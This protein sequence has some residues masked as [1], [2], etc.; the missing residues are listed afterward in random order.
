ME[1]DLYFGKVFALWLSS[2]VFAIT[3]AI[4]SD[5]AFKEFQCAFSALSLVTQGGVNVSNCW[6]NST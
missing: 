6:F 3:N 2:G 4:F 5:F 1:I